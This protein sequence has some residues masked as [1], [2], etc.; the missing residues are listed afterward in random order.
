[1][2]VYSYYTYMYNQF[3]LY[4]E[5][6]IIILCLCVCESVY[7]RNRATT[8]THKHR[9]RH[10]N[11]IRFSIASLGR[12]ICTLSRWNNDFWGKNSLF[13]LAQYTYAYNTALARYSQAAT[14]THTD[15]LLQHIYIYIWCVYELGVECYTKKYYVIWLKY[16]CK[17]CRYVIIIRGDKWKA[18]ALATVYTSVMTFVNIIYTPLFADVLYTTRKCA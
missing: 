14:Y 2:C 16:V 4:L 17:V 12:G 11:V 5:Y 7:I 15:T 3:L 10:G 1:M 18:T 13:P 9:H 6:I 8:R